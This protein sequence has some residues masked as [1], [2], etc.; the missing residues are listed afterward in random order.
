MRERPL[1]RAGYVVRVWDLPTRVFHALLAVG[2]VA[3]IVTAKLGGAAQPWHFRAGY[4]VWAL[5]MFRLLWGIWGGRWSR[6]STFAPAPAAVWR[7]LRGGADD[8]TR[9]FGL[10]HTPLGG[11]SVWAMLSVLAL[12][13]ATGVFADDD[14]GDTGPWSRFAS[15]RVVAALTHWHRHW[16]PWAI[17]VLLGLHVGAIAYQWR[18]RGNNLLRPMWS[19]DKL[20]AERAPPS[21]DTPRRRALA[22]GLLAACGALVVWLVTASGQAL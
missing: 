15:D 16:G 2:V 9:T 17:Y 20:V 7:H 1:P 19:G 12:Q 21:I 11:L 5:L 10:G 6:F 4:A 14:I 3:L 8:P 18:V 22:L 13:V